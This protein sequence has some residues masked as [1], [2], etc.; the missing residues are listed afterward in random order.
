[1][2]YELATYIHSVEAQVRDLT[3]QL[4]EARAALSEANRRLAEIKDELCGNGLEVAGWHQNG[5]L[6]PLDSWFEQN[7]WGPVES[8]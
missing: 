3:A 6:E 1:M 2:T 5:D 7:D 8:K 4:T